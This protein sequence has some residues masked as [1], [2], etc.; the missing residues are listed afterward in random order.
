MIVRPDGVSIVDKHSRLRD[1]STPR[2]LRTP[3]GPKTVPA[4]AVEVQAYANVG[5]RA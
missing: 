5:A 1:V 2:E 4:V 3:K